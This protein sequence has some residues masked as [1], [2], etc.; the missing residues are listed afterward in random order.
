MTIVRTDAESHR[1][2]AAVTPADGADLPHPAQALW[3]GGA[4]NVKV[5]MDSSGTVTFNGVA[6]GTMLPAAVTRVHAT[7]TTATNILALW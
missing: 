1:N 4:G 2:A 6:A 5:T 3:V 7:G